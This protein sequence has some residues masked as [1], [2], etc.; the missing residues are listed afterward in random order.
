M[1][2]KSGLKAAATAGE[3]CVLTDPVTGAAMQDE[4]GPVG[5][6]LAGVDSEQYAAAEVAAARKRSSLAEKQ[7]RKWRFTPEMQREENLEML[8]ACT[9][10]WS[11]CSYNGESE[12]SKDLIRDLYKDERSIREQ[13]EAFIAD[14]A[15]FAKASPAT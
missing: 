10:D 4:L 3:L 12:F 15:S 1:D 6:Y 7:G 5:L 11:N 2:L 8:V 9:L 14:R 13:A